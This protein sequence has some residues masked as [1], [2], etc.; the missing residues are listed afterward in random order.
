VETLRKEFSNV[1]DLGAYTKNSYGQGISQHTRS[2]RWQCCLETFTSQDLLVRACERVEA[3]VCIVI[4]MSV[5]V[6]RSRKRREVNP[7]FVASCTLH[8]RHGI[9]RIE[10]HQVVFCIIRACCCWSGVLPSSIKTWVQL[11]LCYSRVRL[12]N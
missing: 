4:D 11:T 3:S 6:G 5:A 10:R 2:R 9:Q 8:R 12:S 7:F 1:E